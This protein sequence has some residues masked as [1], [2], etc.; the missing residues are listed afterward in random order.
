MMLLPH[1]HGAF[2]DACGPRAFAPAGAQ[3]AA[4]WVRLADSLLFAKAKTQR[5]LEGYSAACC[6][7]PTVASAFEGLPM[8][9]EALLL[10]SESL[11]SG[12][13][14]EVCESVGNGI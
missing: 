5:R 13:S 7:T 1:T 6:W 4:G 2:W 3:L 12:T 10:L 9:I 14:C 8:Q 11:T